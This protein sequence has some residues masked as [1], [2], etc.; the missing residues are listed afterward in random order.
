LKVFVWTV[1][2]PRKAA[3]LINAGIDGIISNK[4]SWLRNKL[5][6]IKARNPGLL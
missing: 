6:E 4:S 3:R 1:D 2:N 5:Q